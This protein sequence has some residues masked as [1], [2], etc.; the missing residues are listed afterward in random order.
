M[1]KVSLARLKLFTIKRPVK[2]PFVHQ[3]KSVNKR[4]VKPSLI[5]YYP[6]LKLWQ[7]GTRYIADL[8]AKL[9]D[10]Y[11]INIVTSST[12]QQLTKYFQDKGVFIINLNIPSTNSPFFWILSPLW[13]V[14]AII[15]TL[16]IK[17][18][19]YVA[20]LFPSTVIMA[21]CSLIKDLP[22]IHFC[23]EPVPWIHNNNY[24]S[25]HKLINRFIF[26]VISIC[27]K[28]IDVWS[29]R[30]AKVTITLDEYKSKLIKD[31]YQVNPKVISVGIDS[32][33]F[34]PINNK[35]N[36][37]FNR[38]KDKMIILHSTDYTPIKRTNE[39]LRIFSIVKKVVND[40]H[41]LITST[42]TG[43]REEKELITL[44]RSLG[45]DSSTEFLG[46][47]EYNKLPH[48][49]NIAKCYLSLSTEPMTATN[50]P[51]KE[52]LM[53]GTFAVRTKTGTDDVIN[54][55][56]GY[57]VDPNNQTD[58]VRKIS[59]LLNRPDRSIKEKIKIRNTIINKYRWINV[60]QRFERHI[61]PYL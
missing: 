6:H 37:Y 38:Y 53:C 39:V 50:L 1:I 40:S 27:F 56:T 16:S 23:Y 48:I 14:I 13:I 25:Q 33:H 34:R 9:K 26:T 19:I 45:I 52:A 44:S 31:V 28:K 57:I 29:T 15:K 22:L 59:L 43:V 2:H 41:L 51:V 20:T 21:F 11:K 35:N 3:N 58:L 55:K 4:F 46:T 17:A 32:R 60:A 12:N 7:G 42:R 49:Y 30:K 8:S 5:W 61:K 24:I 36:I 10:K 18:D 47:I 54:N